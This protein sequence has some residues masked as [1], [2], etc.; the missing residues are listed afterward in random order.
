[1]RRKFLWM[2]GTLL[3]TVGGAAASIFCEEDTGTWLWH[4]AVGQNT[5]RYYTV[6]SI[7]LNC[8]RML[9]T[10]I[11]DCAFFH[12]TR[13]D[14]HYSGNVWQV[15]DSDSHTHRLLC[16]TDIFIQVE[17][18]P[19]GVPCL[20]CFTKVEVST[21]IHKGAIPV[22]GQPYPSNYNGTDIP[23]PKSRII[24]CGPGG[25]SGGGGPSGGPR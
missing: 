18:V 1:M 3:L 25:T 21:W 10:G 22:P 16:N 24:V 15:I 2:M 8:E 5:G 14:C 17:K 19:L 4:L 20:S 11:D 13:W 9:V 7:Y 12:E 6:N 23:N